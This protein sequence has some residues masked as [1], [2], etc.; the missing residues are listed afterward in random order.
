MF[1]AHAYSTASGKDTVNE[2]A[3][4][5]RAAQSLAALLRLNGYEMDADELAAELATGRV[6][7]HGSFL[8]WCKEAA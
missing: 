4:M 8:Y 3:S 1:Q 2:Y 5:D 6:V 7:A